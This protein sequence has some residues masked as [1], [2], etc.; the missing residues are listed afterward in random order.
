MQQAPENS[1][2]LGV[3][4]DFEP[5][6]FGALSARLDVAYKD[7]YVFQ[8]LQNRYD[9]ADDRTLVNGR[10]SLNDIAV[11]GDEG[12]LRVS[13]GDSRLRRH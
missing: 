10:L 11:G 6:S 5:F 4:Y 2:S 7:E 13:L 3:Q 8:P 9:S 12:A 1:A